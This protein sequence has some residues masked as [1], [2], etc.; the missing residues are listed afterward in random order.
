MLTLYR[1]LRNMARNMKPGLKAVQ[2]RLL[3]DSSLMYRT[4]HKQHKHTRASFTGLCTVTT[5][6]LACKQKVET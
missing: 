2:A 5:L 3:L 6:E 1:S 4:L